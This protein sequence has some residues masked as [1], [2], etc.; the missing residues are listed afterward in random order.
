M[1][2]SKKKRSDTKPPIFRPLPRSA[3]HEVLLNNKCLQICKY[4]RDRPSAI[5][6]AF[7]STRT[8][9]ALVPLAV[10]NPAFCRPGRLQ[11]A[12][13][14]GGCLKK[15]ACV[16]PIRRALIARA[17]LGVCRAQA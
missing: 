1:L 9:P 17:A 10:V 6:M 2:G 15:P 4:D 11:V 16:R 8:A 5:G 7:N 13:L 12:G 3:C 14:S